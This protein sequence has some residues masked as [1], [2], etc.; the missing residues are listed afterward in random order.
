MTIAMMSPA[1]FTHWVA[2]E[3]LSTSGGKVRL[4]RYVCLTPGNG[5][6]HTSQNLCNQLLATMDKLKTAPPLRNRIRL[7]TGQGYIEDFIAV[8]SWMHRNLDEVRKLTV[9][10]YLP[11][12]PSE[13][14]IKVPGAKIKLDEVF[15]VGG[16]FTDGMDH[17]VAAG[18]FGWDCIGFVSQYLISIGHLGEY[19][20]WKSHHY[21]SHGNFKPIASLAD[22]KPLCIGVFGESHIVLID[23]VQDISLDE[24]T[25]ALTATV[26]VSQSYSKGPQT[27]EQCKLTQ[28]RVAW[29]K[30]GRPVYGPI[31]QT[32]VLDF[33]TQMTVARHDDIVVQYPPYAPVSQKRASALVE[34][35]VR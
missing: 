32:G 18:C 30:D 19:P 1:D 20:T 6:S 29:A 21:I 13:G 17:L 5:G 28:G 35:A 16:A 33:A 12:N 31:V 8:W 11:D 4:N 23:K 15:K 2:V 27:R 34:S 7:S 9:Q 14:R 26:S 22:I 3:G 25:G 10:T 24:Q